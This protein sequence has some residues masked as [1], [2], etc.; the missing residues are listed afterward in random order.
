MYSA[1][2][3]NKIAGDSS[4]HVP[5]VRKFVVKRTSLIPKEVAKQNQ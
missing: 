3:E 1:G 4:R 2:I 5:I